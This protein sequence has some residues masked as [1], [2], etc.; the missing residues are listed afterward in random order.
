MID[1]AV[2]SDTSPRLKALWDELGE[3][4]AAWS[5][6]LIAHRDAPTRDDLPA[7]LAVTRDAALRC[8]VALRK[9]AATDDVVWQGLGGDPSRDVPLG[10]LAPDRAPQ[11]K[12]WADLQLVIRRL[13]T[14][15]RTSDAVLLAEAFEFVAEG[16]RRVLDA[17]TR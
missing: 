17:D 2:V 3:A 1:T 4:E 12:E 8:A 6:A 10:E 11:T 15:A 5:A 14:A 16:I 9:A 7:R 13:S